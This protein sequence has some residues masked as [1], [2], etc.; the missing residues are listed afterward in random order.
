MGAMLPAGRDSR[1]DD[2]PI[3]LS[4][5]R[6]AL[7][8]IVWAAA[9]VVLAA[10]DNGLMGSAQE[11][12]GD[13]CRPRK[14]AGVESCTGLDMGWQECR[15]YYRATGPAPKQWCEELRRRAGPEAIELRPCVFDD[16]RNWVRVPC[17]RYGIAE[18]AACYAC[19][20][21][22]HEVQMTHVYGYDA[23]CLRGV[24]QITCNFDALEA[25]RIMGGGRDAR[26]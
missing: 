13:D 22:Q 19:F 24:A 21:D 25:G 14:L 12:S 26:P 4:A 16:A 17:S 15:S 20:V 3:T 10:C 9:P 18:V 1:R 5:A 2:L 6:R 8:G 11:L 7:R 23:D